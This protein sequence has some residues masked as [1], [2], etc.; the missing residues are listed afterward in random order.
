MSIE[1]LA[2]GA[3]QL[4]STLLDLFKDSEPGSRHVSQRATLP[5]PV[6]IAGYEAPEGTL[7]FKTYKEELSF[8]VPRRRDK[9][10]EVLLP[11]TVRVDNS[12]VMRG[13]KK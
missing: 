3:T 11:V 13:N 7:V 1:V 2:T 12:V 6:K 4:R 9:N 10:D 5:F 8:H